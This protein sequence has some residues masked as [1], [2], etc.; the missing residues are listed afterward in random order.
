MPSW[1]GEV[2]LPRAFAALFVLSEFGLPLPSLG[3]ICLFFAKFVI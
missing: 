2:T 1:L 3:F